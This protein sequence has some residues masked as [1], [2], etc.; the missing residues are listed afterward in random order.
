MIR[1][2]TYTDAAAIA[3]VY[4]HYVLNTVVTFEEL[5]I[6]AEEMWSRVEAVQLAGYPWL[7]FEE[8]R[9]VAGYAY[10]NAWKVRAAYRHSVEIS[11]YLGPS[12][13]GRGLGKLLYTCS[14]RWRG[15]AER[16]QC[17]AVRRAR[18]H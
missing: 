10:A 6:S 14:N 3:E 8:D 5:A 15:I 12:F 4:N 1:N 16:C 18:F 2:A 9:K 7:V 11:V 13:T 17:K